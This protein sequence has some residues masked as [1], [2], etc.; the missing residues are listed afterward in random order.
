[1]PWKRGTHHFI[2][3][4]KHKFMTDSWD[5]LFFPSPLLGRYG[6]D[7]FAILLP[8]SDLAG[9]RLVAERLRGRIGYTALNTERGPI[10]MTLSLGVVALNGRCTDL[11]ALLER[12]DQALY[13][14]K[15]TGRDRVCVWQG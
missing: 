6:G 2:R 10:T 15:Q 9:A 1:M 13:V 7:E 14:A 11:E 3:D 8:E 12:A 4:D 5:D